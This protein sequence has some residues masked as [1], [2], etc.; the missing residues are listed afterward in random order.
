[1][2]T[3]LTRLCAIKGMCLSY[4]VA[5]YS[6]FKIMLNLMLILI[7]KL[8]WEIDM[9][10]LLIIYFFQVQR[11]RLKFFL[12]LKRTPV[13]SKK[14][15]I[16]W[17]LCILLVNHHFL[18][19]L[20]LWEHGLATPASMAFS[21]KISILWWLCMLFVNHHFL[22]HLILLRAWPC[23]SCFHGFILLTLILVRVIFMYMIVL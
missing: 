23:H 1:M 3:L 11:L 10:Y 17:W 5:D 6:W 12:I 9:F 8:I 21:K 16:L 7:E 14:F 4:T 18:I 22:I 2:Q 15:S 13:V 19:H 20:I